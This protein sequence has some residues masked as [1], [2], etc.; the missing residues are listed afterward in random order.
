MF[1]NR[2]GQ[3][4]LELFSMQAAPS[5][6]CRLSPWL[7]L[8]RRLRLQSF[9]SRQHAEALGKEVKGHLFRLRLVMIG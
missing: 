5:Q 4:Q 8:L 7:S 2:S 9:A 6:V 1:A 3:P